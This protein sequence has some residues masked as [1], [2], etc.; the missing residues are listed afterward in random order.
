MKQVILN[1]LSNA[2][3]FTFEGHILINVEKYQHSIVIGVEDTGIGIKEEDLNK[4]FQ[5]FTKI[6]LGDK[7]TFN[8]T[9][10]GLGLM[11]SN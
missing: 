2:L 5:K 4:L 11:I 10:A 3:K 8:S 9:G 7:I 6:D 1:L